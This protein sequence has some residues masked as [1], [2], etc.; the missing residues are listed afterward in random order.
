MPISE[1]EH[2]RLERLLS[3]FCEEQGPPAHVKD[4]L[5]WGF[6]VDPEHQV[7]ELFEVRPHFRLEGKI[8]ESRVAK[9]TYVKKT[10]MWKLY[11]MRGNMK[12]TR[13]E[14]RPEVKTVEEFLIVV[15]E[16][17]YSCFFG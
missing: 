16:D 2:A 11:W 12:W 10:K 9:A 4:Q 8:V 17:A 13:Y 1:F 3:Q 14:P 5:R 6:R 7:V 15:K